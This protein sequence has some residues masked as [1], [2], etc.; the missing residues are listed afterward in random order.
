MRPVAMAIAFVALVAGGG[1]AYRAHLLDG[2]PAQ[3][4][5]Q[6]RAAPA[7]PVLVA[8]AER[9]AIPVR[10]DAIGT[11]QTFA[12]VSVKSRIDAQIAEVKVNDG[13]YVKKGDT[14]FQL[15]SRAA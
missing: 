8:T 14:L 11:V 10:L 9:E 12:T 4:T 5:E 6:P 15:D 2:A 3:T 1:I 13:Q 7:I